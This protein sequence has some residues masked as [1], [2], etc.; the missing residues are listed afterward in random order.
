[1]NPTK[2]MCDGQEFIKMN[3]FPMSSLQAERQ[4]RSLTAAGFGARITEGQ[5]GFFVWMS[6]S[7]PERAI[8][9]AKWEKMREDET[10]AHLNTLRDAVIIRRDVK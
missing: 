4:S 1:M 6:D 7:D 9:D 8:F 3:V 2:Q 10:R 5:S